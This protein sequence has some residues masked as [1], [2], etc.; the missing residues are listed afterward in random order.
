FALDAVVLELD[1][2]RDLAAPGQLTGGSARGRVLRDVGVDAGEY[3]E[4]PLLTEDLDEGRDDRVRGAR[5]VRVRHGDEALVLRIREVLPALGERQAA[6]G[7]LVHDEADRPGV[8]REVGAT[9][10]VD[11]ALVKIA[12][13]RGLVELGET[14]AAGHDARV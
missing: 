12:P 4:G 14:L 7:V 1:G 2:D 9:H 13:D 11:E 8:Q 5:A 10:L 6:Q 3:L